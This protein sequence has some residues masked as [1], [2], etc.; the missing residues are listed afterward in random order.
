MK[1]AENA[2]SLEEVK[3]SI[4]ELNERVSS[5]FAE[6][7]GTLL[8]VTNNLAGSINTD[9]VLFAKETLERVNLLRCLASK[10]A[11]AN[12]YELLNEA[13]RGYTS[14]FGLFKDEETLDKIIET[15][16]RRGYTVLTPGEVIEELRKDLN[17]ERRQRQELEARVRSLETG[18]H[19][20]KKVDWT[21]VIL[22][23]IILLFV[24]MILAQKKP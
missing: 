17:E 23:I 18:V 10:P 2:E 15:Q 4:K 21:P 20:A 9:I 12:L 24:S 14:A 22:M 6:I 16:K 3:K 1:K 8:A 5:G 19:Q 11:L 13:G 7:R